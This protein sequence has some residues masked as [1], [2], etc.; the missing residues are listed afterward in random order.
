MPDAPEEG[1]LAPRRTASTSPFG[2]LAGSTGPPPR[3]VRPRTAAPL[4][5]P[6]MDP[7]AA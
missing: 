4:L 2:T 1:G 5:A 7:R 6:P 3:R